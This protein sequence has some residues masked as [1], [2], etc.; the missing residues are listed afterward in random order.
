[1]VR[2]INSD[3]TYQVGQMYTA[4]SF[5]QS[6]VNL[7]GTLYFVAISGAGRE[8]WKSDGTQQ[9]A[10]LV[11]DINPG[12]LNS[13]YPPLTVQDGPVELFESERN[14]N[15]SLLNGPMEE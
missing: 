5:P 12:S 7:N 2:D 14:D 15:S 11:K 8:L 13:I 3:Y 9:G 6:L 10:V 4:D 1:M